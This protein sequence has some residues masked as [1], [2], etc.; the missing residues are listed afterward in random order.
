MGKTQPTYRDKLRR[1]EADWEPFER[2][3]RAQ[4][5][6]DWKQLW[7]HARNYADAAGIQNEV[8][9]IEPFLVTVCLG[10]QKQIRELEQRVAELE[11]EEE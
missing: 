4:Y 5:Q 11:N 8:T 6:A 2:A 3:L 1:L 9:T 7:N 10:Q